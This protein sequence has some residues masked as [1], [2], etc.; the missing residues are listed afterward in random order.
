MHITTRIRIWRWLLSYLISSKEANDKACEIWL[1]LRLHKDMATFQTLET[2]MN[3][4]CCHN[5][6]VTISFS[7]CNLRHFKRVTTHYQT[8]QTWIG[9]N[10]MSYHN[11]NAYRTRHGIFSLE[12]CLVLGYLQRVCYHHF[13]KNIDIFF[14]NSP[15]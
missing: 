12:I 7:K 14:I 9:F 1:K 4:P 3:R 11:L 8:L 10:V 15:K 5:W 13:F 6:R 2:N